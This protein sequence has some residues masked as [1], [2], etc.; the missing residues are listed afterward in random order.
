MRWCFGM[1]GVVLA[2]TTDKYM[3]TVLL[4]LLSLRL[5]PLCKTVLD[6]STHSPLIDTIA[7]RVSIT[8]GLQ[9]RRN[10]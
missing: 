2:P 5:L 4:L 3:L 10:L 6:V 1:L 8:P 9:V 7:H